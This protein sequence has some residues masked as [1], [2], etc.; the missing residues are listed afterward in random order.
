MTQPQRAPSTASLSQ[1]SL[2]LRLHVTAPVLGAT[3]APCLSRVLHVSLTE[4]MS[5]VVVGRG[6]ALAQAATAETATSSLNPD[7]T[8]TSRRQ[9]A[10]WFLAKHAALNP[11]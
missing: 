10:R 6:A 1:G 3:G 4:R 5:S 11:N 7:R 2:K 9:A 8:A